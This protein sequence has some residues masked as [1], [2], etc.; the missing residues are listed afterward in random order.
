V[1]NRE[2]GEL[3][4]FYE[5]EVRP[6]SPGARRFDMGERSDFAALPTAIASM[7]LIQSWTV[8]EVAGRLQHLNKLIW[9][10]AP[11]VG[12]TVPD[13]RMRPPHIAILD[14]GEAIGSRAKAWLKE[15]GI[16][17]TTRGAKVRVSPHV[18]N[19]DGDIARL[20]DGL[21]SLRARGALSS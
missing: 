16:H 10:L 21:S 20:F 8:D 7:K 1:W 5:M 4:D 15:Q 18:Y 17:V 19:D 14:I 11:T 13:A 2:G 12:A 3:P 6:Y 9:E